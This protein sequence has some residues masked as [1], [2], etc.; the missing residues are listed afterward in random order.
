MPASQIC[1]ADSFTE[2]ASALS[3]RLARR[4]FFLSAI[5][6]ILD[7]VVLLS[8]CGCDVQQLEPL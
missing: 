5:A 3:N 7:H 4:C 1:C 6:L 8:G 2:P